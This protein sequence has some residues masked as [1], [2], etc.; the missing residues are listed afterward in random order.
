MGQSESAFSVAVF[1]DRTVLSTTLRRLDAG[2][3]LRT[4]TL[5]KLE[6]FLGKPSAWILTG[7]EVEG[8]RLCD[9]PGWNEAAAKATERFGFS[10]SQI[11]GAG[12]M[13]VPTMPTRMDEVVVAGFVRAWGDAQ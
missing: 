8:I 3:G 9:V 11:E 7:D 5:E 1:G 12:R 6:Q 4:P 2:G 13:R 10:S